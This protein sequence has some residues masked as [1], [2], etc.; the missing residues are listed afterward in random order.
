[1]TTFEDDGQEQMENLARLAHGV[2]LAVE[3]LEDEFCG[4]G[5]YPEHLFTSMRRLS[6]AA[7][8]VADISLDWAQVSNADFEPDNARSEQQ[9]KREN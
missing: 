6:A 7:K 1:M 4:L 8:A 3:R 5:D 9:P 2:K